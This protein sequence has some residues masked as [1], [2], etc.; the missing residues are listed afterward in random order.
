MAPQLRAARA[1]LG[2]TRVQ[3]AEASGVNK[4]TLADLEAGKRTARKGTAEKVRAAFEGAGLRLTARG[5]VE[6]IEAN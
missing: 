6:P 3:L 2:W 4:R 1:Y 5:G